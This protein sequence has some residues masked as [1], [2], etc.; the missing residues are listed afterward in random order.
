MVNF[1][2]VFACAKRGDKD[3]H[4]SFFRLPKIRLTEGSD[5]SKMADSD[6]LSVTMLN[7]SFSRIFLITLSLTSANIT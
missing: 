4:L 1:C 6:F 3:R 5:D 2:G 7:F